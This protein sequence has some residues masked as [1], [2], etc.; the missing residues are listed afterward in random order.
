MSVSQ[1]LLRTGHSSSSLAEFS[2][3]NASEDI[4][5]RVL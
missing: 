1:S 2:L 5:N 4:K 3:R